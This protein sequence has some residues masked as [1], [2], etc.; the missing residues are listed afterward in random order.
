MKTIK[1]N[2]EQ[3]TVKTNDSNYE[4]NKSFTHTFYLGDIKVKITSKESI[5]AKEGDFVIVAG[6]DGLDTIFKAYS[7]KN[8]N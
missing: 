4:K 1:G 7:F 5:D 8:L 2:I 3:L 6:E